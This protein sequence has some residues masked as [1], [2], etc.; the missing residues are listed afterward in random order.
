MDVRLPNGNVI[1]GVPDNITQA[2]LVAK[3]ERNGIDYKAP[4]D[5]GTLGTFSDFG[6]AAVHHLVNPVL[7]IGQAAMHGASAVGIGQDMTKRFDNYIAKREQEYQ[8]DT[9]TNAASLAGAAVG[10]VL[11][12]MVGAGAA[13]TALKTAS[14][15]QKIAQGM[16]QGAK[17]SLVQPVNDTSDGYAGEKIA[18]GLIGG[19]TGGIVPG[20]AATGKVVKGAVAPLTDSGRQKIVA[21]LLTDKTGMTPQDLA[22]ALKNVPQYVPGSVPTT[23][24]AVP[25]PGIVQVEKAIRNRPQLREGFENLENQNNAARM[26][27]VRSVAKDEH[28]LTE[29]KNLRE[30]TVRPLYDEAHNNEALVTNRTVNNIFR[31]PA[32]Q[33]AMQDAERLAANERV[34]LKWP[35]QEDPYISGRALDYTKRALDDQISAAQRSGSAQEVRALMGLKDSLTSFEERNIGGIKEARQQYRNL[36]VP[37]NTMETGQA[38]LGTLENGALNSAGEVAPGLAAYRSRLAQALKNADFGIDPNAQ[39]T[40]EAVQNDLQRASISNS[41]RSPGSDTVYNGMADGWLARSLYGSGFEGGTRAGKVLA[42]LLGGATKGPVGAYLGYTGAEKLA[43]HVSDKLNEKL[44]Q[45]LMDKDFAA[46]MLLQ[47]SGLPAQTRLPGMVSP[48]LNPLITQ[49]ALQLT[50]P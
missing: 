21:Q 43:N 2:E 20:L 10:E 39:K 37:V 34:K 44:A 31:A 29:A 40:L 38:L 12:W 36:S 42:G 45:A 35:T 33:Q 4:E 3:L 6:N 8:R 17:I 5:H 11:P 49:G 19:A 25:S 41:L 26:N 15:G 28:T 13:N 9:P 32:I 22:K 7:G 30:S 14:M 46:Q 23:A 27:A 50:R 18:Q 48:V 24:Q 1:R 47:N 16:G